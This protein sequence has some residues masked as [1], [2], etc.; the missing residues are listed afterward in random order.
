MFGIWNA[1]KHF[2]VAPYPVNP[3]GDILAPRRA[4]TADKKFVRGLF[5]FVRDSFGSTGYLVLNRG[6]IVI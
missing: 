3:F 5:D 1:R 4:E 2:R 6:E